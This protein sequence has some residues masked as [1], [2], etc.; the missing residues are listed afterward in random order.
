MERFLSYEKTFLKIQIGLASILSFY[1]FLL[2]VSDKENF[3]ML[4]SNG[5]IVFFTITS[6]ILSRY[7]T[8]YNFNLFLVLK[9]LHLIAY[10]MLIFQNNTFLFGI[11]I[12]AYIFFSMELFITLGSDIS[13]KISLYLLVI[14]PIV[15][16]TIIATQ[17]RES[18]EIFIF[19]LMLIMV[20][21]GIYKVIDQYHEEFNQMISFQAQDLETSQSINMT[22]EQSQEKMKQ[23]YNQI[24]KQKFEIEQTNKHL[25]RM[26]AEMYIQ[27]ELLQ[28]ITTTLDIDQL[29][30]LVT[31]SVIG[32]IGT[33]TCSLLIYEDDEKT[34]YA[35]SK[36]TVDSD[37]TKH[38]IKLVESGE[39]APYMA[40]KEILLDEDVTID[41]YI[42]TNNAVVGS[43]I[44]VP[45]VRN[46]KV[47]GLIIA[48]HHQKNYFTEN[49]V[50]FFKA[51]G[52]QVNIAVHNT[53][54][55]RQME[56]MAK[57][58]SLTQLFN[59]RTFQDQLEIV[60]EQSVLEN[61]T[62]SVILF[63]IDFFKN[64]NDTY[65]HLVGDHI[66]EAVAEITKHYAEHN[67][68]FAGRYGGE[69]F[70]MV[71]PKK[72]KEQIY[73]IIATMHEEIK[74]KSVVV[75]DH[76]I[77]IDVSIGITRYPEFGKSAED[78]VNRAD[79]AMYYAKNHGRG[80]I[81]L[82]NKELFP[83]E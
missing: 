45:L 44:L 49:S 43:M 53:N 12:I 52:T 69:E 7:Q 28:Y 71:I 63:D 33:D 23:V 9:A 47:F 38:F 19:L 27:N 6:L 46:D 15:V 18:A 61:N 31:D 51:I 58:D 74:S 4:F 68:G 50:E 10:S 25:E 78:L 14:S 1:S 82:D 16:T 67:K 54:I 2:M 13:K 81:Q 40:S 83:S 30:D 76:E 75:G 55:Y 48:E 21:M 42:F 73:G 32:A 17:L 56:E 24:S 35:E 80:R 60:Y 39:M 64:V 62:F 57:I 29:L 59:R 70:V 41:E 3:L 79:T 20:L 26:T 66:I 34:F 5:L 77:F 8:I 65:G 11:G 36:S 72:N 37:A 22:L